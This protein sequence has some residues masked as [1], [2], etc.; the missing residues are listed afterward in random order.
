M[1]REKFAAEH[2]FSETGLSLSR[3]VE[4]TILQDPDHVGR[5]TAKLLG[6]VVAALVNANALPADKVE[7]MLIEII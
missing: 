5:R 3:R 4:E 6:L 7:D 2:T 1:E